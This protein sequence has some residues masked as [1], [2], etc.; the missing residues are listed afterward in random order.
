MIDVAVRHVHEIA[1]KAVKILVEALDFDENVPW[2]V[3]ACRIMPEDDPQGP[4]IG[5][6]QCAHGL[7][8]SFDLHP[9]A[10]E[11]REYFEGEEPCLRP[12][13]SG[14]EPPSALEG[15]FS[16]RLG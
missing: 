14:E 12:P 3:S 2:N 1:R 11:H 13:V 8:P 6:C 7:V 15:A 9:F 16:L 10:V 4:P 5:R